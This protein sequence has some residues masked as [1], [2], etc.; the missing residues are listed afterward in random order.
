MNEKHYYEARPASK[1]MFVGVV[2]HWDTSGNIELIDCRTD[3]CPTQ[4]EAI[5]AASDWAEKNE[6]EAELA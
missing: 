6:I 2:Y 1:G 5:E 3:P 4:R